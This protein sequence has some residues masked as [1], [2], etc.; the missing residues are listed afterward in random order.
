[1]LIIG[2][3]VFAKAP[4][5]LAVNNRLGENAIATHILMLFSVCT[6]YIGNA[7]VGRECGIHLRLGLEICLFC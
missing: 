3:V 1:M 5:A 2:G 4:K 7:A 6:N